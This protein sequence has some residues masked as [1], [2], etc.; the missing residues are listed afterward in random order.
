LRGA[1]GTSLTTL[2]T[3]A[4]AGHTGTAYCGPTKH[5]I[6]GGGSAAAGDAL[7]GSFPSNSSGVPATSGMPSHWTVTTSGSVGGG[8]V[9]VICA[10]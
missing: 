5:A 7:T 10:P 2:I 9:Y 6:G 1:S 4:I 3:E 8:T